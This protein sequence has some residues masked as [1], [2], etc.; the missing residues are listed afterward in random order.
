[1]GGKNR[2]T[3]NDDQKRGGKMSRDKGYMV[4]WFRIFTFISHSAIN[5]CVTVIPAEAGIQ[6]TAW[7]PGQAR[8]D[9]PRI[10]NMLKIL[11]RLV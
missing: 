4:D 11:R 3:P 9:R 2:E 8:N 1:M 6:K 7:I 5:K 10:V